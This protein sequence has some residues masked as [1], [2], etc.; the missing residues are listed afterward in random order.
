MRQNVCGYLK[1]AGCFYLCCTVKSNGYVWAVTNDLEWLINKQCA[2]LLSPAFSHCPAVLEVQ[3]SLSSGM[4]SPVGSAG[5]QRG[6]GGEGG[7]SL[8]M[9]VLCEK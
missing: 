3:S 5:D 6:G 4:Q 9:T 2:T 1:L 8:T 7:E